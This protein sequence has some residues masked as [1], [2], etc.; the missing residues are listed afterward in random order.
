MVV[1]ASGGKVAQVPA[2]RVD[3]YD[4]AGAGDTVIAT[5]ALCSALGPLSE[6]S[7]YLATHTAA[8]VVRKPG[9]A[10]PSSD[11]LEQIGRILG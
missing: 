10:V 9:V 4:E 6:T 3:V 7:L 8:S 11:D 2:V 5:L 1:A